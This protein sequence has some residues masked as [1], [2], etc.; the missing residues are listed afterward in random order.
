MIAFGAIRFRRR[1]GGQHLDYRRA[2]ASD[3]LQMADSGDATLGGVSNQAQPPLSLRPE[4]VL[5]DRQ[6][7]ADERSALMIRP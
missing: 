7:I 5:C 2:V 4:A 1:S 6:M 3:G